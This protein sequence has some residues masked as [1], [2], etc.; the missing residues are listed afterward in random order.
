[1]DYVLQDL[2]AWKFFWKSFGMVDTNVLMCYYA[3]TR[4]VTPKFFF[5]RSYSLVVLGIDCVERQ[6]I[7]VPCLT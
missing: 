2:T 3:I 6:R 7:R 4:P 5:M 1:M